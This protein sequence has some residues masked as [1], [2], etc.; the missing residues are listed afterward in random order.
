[1]LKK[2]NMAMIMAGVTVATSVAPVFAAQE[3]VKQN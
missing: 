3:E 2:K 1:M